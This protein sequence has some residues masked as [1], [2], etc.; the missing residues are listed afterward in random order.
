MDREGKLEEIKYAL[1]EAISFDDVQ[2][3]NILD[4]FNDLEDGFIEE[5]DA[6]A[7]IVEAIKENINSL[8]SV[9]DRSKNNNVVVGG[10]DL[11]LLL[12]V[13]LNL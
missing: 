6:I 11:V 4:I 1:K 7:K 2:F 3:G 12:V 13:L 5:E 10:V 9:G 8:N